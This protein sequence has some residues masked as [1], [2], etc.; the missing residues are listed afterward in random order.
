MGGEFS[1]AGTDVRAA[2][3]STITGLGWMDEIRGNS[4]NICAVAVIYGGQ[5][6]DCQA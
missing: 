5:D 4:V 6:L 1:S 2:V 3:F